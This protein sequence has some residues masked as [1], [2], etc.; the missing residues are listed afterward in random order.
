MNALDTPNKTLFLSYSRR[1]TDWCN[2]LYTAIDTYT[3]YYRWRDNK[4][5]E[6]ADWWNS[7]CLNIEGC[8][9]FVALLTE[10]YLKSVYCMGELEYALKLNKPI[11]ALKLQDGDYPQK[12]NEMRLQFARVMNLDMPQV[13]I[14]VMNACD[15]IKTGYMQDKY[16]LD[17]HARP[18]MRPPVP[19]PEKSTPT[20]KE[21]SILNEQVEEVAIHGQ[22][23]TRDLIRRYSEE[24]DNNIRLARDLLNKIAE[25]D[26]IPVFF[27]MKGENAELTIAEKRLA[28][29]E[30]KRTILKKA[31]EEY[32]DLV[33]YIATISPQRAIVA[34]QKFIDR[35]PDFE[36]AKVLIKDYLPD[37]IDLMPDP[38]DWI[39][40]PGGQVT[41]VTEK[42]WAKNYIAEGSSQTFKV[43]AFEIAKYPVT[44]AQYAKFIE[45]RGYSTQ[46]WWTEAAWQQKQKDNWTE[47][48]F[49][50]DS[51]RNGDL[52][53]VVGV[54][55]YE[56]IAFCHWL[57]AETGENIMLPTEQQWQRAAQGDDGRNY[58]W[59]EDWDSLKCQNS[60]D[61]K[62]GKTSPVT[63]YV[64]KGDSPFNVVDMAGNVW[65]WCLTEYESGLNDMN[66][67]N[68]CVLRGGS[69]LN[70]S[71]DIFRCDFRNWGNPYD[72]FYDGGFRVVRL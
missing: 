1:Q 26:D 5:P 34:I 44:N 23:P 50:Q 40:I 48:R 52:Q 22:I 65:E 72:G 25:R 46:K 12:L 71:S 2:D 69:W 61:S 11:I 33:H 8:F 49:W 32:D 14:K 45:A 43:S 67:T 20:P 60:V 68:V 41:L 31:R 17:I 29:E 28:E 6:S 39:K 18:H 3:H 51:E 56:A 42:G 64:G 70:S 24:K 4:I 38:F 66:G 15:Q 35:Y 16:S 7:I 62:P 30:R 59:G 13:I 37:V 9:A 54:S 36:M 10:D 55:W 27:D 53:P 57:S 47:P 58:P 19:K 21:D 63:L